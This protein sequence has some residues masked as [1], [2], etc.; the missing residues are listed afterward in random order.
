MKKILAMLLAIV[1]VFALVTPV[2]A[3]N[4]GT[5]TGSIEVM[6]P[7]DGVTYTASKIFDATY[8]GTN[9]AYTIDSTSPW[10]STV[11]TFAAT[12]TNGLTLTQVGTT[13]KYNVT[14]DSTKFSAA[15]FAAALK[16]AGVTDSNAKT[17]TATSDD[18]VKVE[19]LELGY[20]LVL[21]S[22]GALANL[23]T[24]K[25]VQI[26]DK[27]E[28]PTPEK[29]EDDTN[30]TVVGA[31]NIGDKIPYVVT[32][33]VPDM[34][35]YVKYFF[36]VTDTMSKGLTFNNDVVIK[37]DGTKLT[38]NDDYTVTATTD[39]STGVTTVKI[40]FKDMV[41]NYSDKA[42]APIEIK[43]SAT[44]N[45]NVEINA[46]NKNEVQIHF[47]NDPSV[48]PQGDDEPGPND[49]PIGESPKSNVLTYVTELP[50]LKTDE[51]SNPLTGAKFRLTGDSTKQII[52]TGDNYVVDANGTYWK[53]K[54]GTYTTTDPTT[55]GVDATKYESTT[56]KYKKETKVTYDTTTTGISPEAFVDASGKVTFTGVGSGT[57]TLSE[58]VVP[59]GYNPI[60]DQTVVVEF[61]LD[62]DSAGVVTGGHFEFKVNGATTGSTYNATNPLTIVN[63]TGAELPQTGGI[64]TTIFYVLG[65]ILVVGASV[66]LVTKKRMG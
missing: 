7:Q 62:K 54:D 58:V 28:V 29:T 41:G 57:Y 17:L 26:Y 24:V 20:W 23:T 36:I 53:L 14:F 9:Y 63:K 15:A 66:M 48:T 46:V 18:T 39:S 38:V 52:V 13:T 1:T 8:S 5:T 64:G 40:V 25:D 33:K 47:S 30:K 35:G 61:V 11:Q 44:V 56:V 22:T 27:N 32:T 31:H 37:V 55:A 21:P 42:G 19:N 59:D 65:G 43:Y 50:I 12:A 34:T 2:S 3:D 51:S 4:S 6:N 60:A 10:F 45:E 16:A 49:P